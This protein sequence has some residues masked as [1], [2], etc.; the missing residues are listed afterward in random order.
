MQGET[1]GL[2][3]G[4]A[5]ETSPV[6]AEPGADRRHDPSTSHQGQSLHRCSRLLPMT[7]VLTQDHVPPFPHGIRSRRSTP[8][9]TCT[10]RPHLLKD[11]QPSPFMKYLPDDF[12]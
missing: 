8:P 1:S 12:C 11:F 6:K 7:S 9:H 3:F 4:F 2:N 10:P 5:W